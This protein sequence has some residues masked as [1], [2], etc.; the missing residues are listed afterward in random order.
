MAGPVAGTDYSSVKKQVL[1]ISAEA[2][3]GTAM[4]TGFKRLHAMSLDV[5]AEFETEIEAAKGARFPTS[6][7][8][9]KDM[10]RAGLTGKPD[11]N[12]IDFALASV[13]CK[14]TATGSAPTVT[15]VYQMLNTAEAGEERQTFTVQYGDD[16]QCETYAGGLLNDFQLQ[17]DREGGI[18][19]SGNMLL[20]ALD[21]TKSLVTSGVTDI[22][23][24]MM[25]SKDVDIW[26]ADTPAGL[27][28]AGNKVLLPFVYTWGINGRADA[29][30]ALNSAYTGPAMYEE[31]ESQGYAGS[32]KVPTLYGLPKFLTAI[33]AGSLVYVRAEARGKKL[34]T[35][36]P[37]V[38][39]LLRV[40]QCWFVQNIPTDNYKAVYAKNVELVGAQS[41]DATWPMSCE[42]TLINGIAAS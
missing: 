9:K 36:T 17:F 34:A 13:L 21:L 16:E 1:Q 6:Q 7:T 32:L 15:R 24:A 38:Y 28:V 37:D 19:M 20:G 23:K 3:P 31:G 18:S 27:G 29:Y 8:M 39:E 2:T 22:A 40:D 14:P 35:G 25:L 41:D 12:E 33:R 4:T 11:F 42:V 30:W 10:A 26:V 5:N